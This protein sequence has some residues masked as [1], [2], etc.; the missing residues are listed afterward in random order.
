MNAI[1]LVM[2]FYQWDKILNAGKI[3]KRGRLSA[4]QL[5]IK[6]SACIQDMSV[7]VS[8]TASFLGLPMGYRNATT[9]VKLIE[10]LV[11]LC[12]QK[13]FVRII[14]FSVPNSAMKVVGML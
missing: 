5:L 6:V 7:A 3:V 14:K 11:F 10:R 8:A 2:I 9:T 4:K 12:L 13:I 1:S